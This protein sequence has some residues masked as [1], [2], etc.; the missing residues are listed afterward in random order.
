MDVL[1]LVFNCYFVTD[2]SNNNNIICTFLKI[3]LFGDYFYD[4]LVSC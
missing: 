2:I 1:I 3:R 4:F